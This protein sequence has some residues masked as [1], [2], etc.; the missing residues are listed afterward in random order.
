M[1]LRERME[2][3]ASLVKKRRELD[4]ESEELSKQ[5][6]AMEQ[7]LID[8]MVAAGLDSVKLA[9]GPR[10]T[11]K[12]TV[13][14]TL[15]EGREAAAAVLKETGYGDLV[16]EN[17]NSA[18]LGALVRELNESGKIPA[19]WEGIIEVNPVTKISVTR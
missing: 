6:T 13:Y 10:I 12:P 9:T 3:Y 14:P 19:K 16:A 7:Q 11:L 18:T 17:F 8:D 4:A 15:P 1:T 2:L 5:Y